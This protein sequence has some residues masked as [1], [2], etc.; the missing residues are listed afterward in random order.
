MF[1]GQIALSVRQGRYKNRLTEPQR[2]AVACPSDSWTGEPPWVFANSS[3]LWTRQWGG[4]NLSVSNPLSQV[5]PS[6][7]VPSPS[8][9]PKSLVHLAKYTGP[10]HHHG[11]PRGHLLSC[12]CS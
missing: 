10:A 3:L 2:I 1:V 4:V 6:L 11:K 5:A 8:P 9:N 12:S 7:R